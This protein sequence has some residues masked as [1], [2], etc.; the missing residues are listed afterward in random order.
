MTG[1]AVC[2][3]PEV[4]VRE[5]MVVG[6]KNSDATQPRED[7]ERGSVWGGGEQTVRYLVAVGLDG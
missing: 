1:G 6:W 4:L 5:E 7:A 3:C 2:F